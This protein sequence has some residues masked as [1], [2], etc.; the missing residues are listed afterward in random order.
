MSLDYHY[1]FTPLP[2]YTVN[3][4]ILENIFSK[5]V[6]QKIPVVWCE[7]NWIWLIFENSNITMFTVRLAAVCPPPASVTN[8]FLSVSS[9]SQCS[10]WQ[11]RL[12]AE[13]INF[14]T[15]PNVGRHPRLQCQGSPPPS[16]VR[17]LLFFDL[18]VTA[19]ITGGHGS[20]RQTGV[21]IVRDHSN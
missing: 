5:S 19:H 20:K 1:P 9:P 2:C 17:H 18:K 10:P 21:F 16:L 12:L 6:S 7:I 13:R 3:L 14:V 15:F 4:K 11:Q 8:C